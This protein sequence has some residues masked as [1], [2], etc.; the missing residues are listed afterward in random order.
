MDLGTDTFS[1][2]LKPYQTDIRFTFILFFF[3]N[4]KRLP[5]S[6]STFFLILVCKKLEINENEG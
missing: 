3:R 5:K 2:Y 4:R 6:V 1:V